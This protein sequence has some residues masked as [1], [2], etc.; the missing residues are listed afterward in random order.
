[1]KTILV[2][3]RPEKKL[4]NLNC[5]VLENLM[6]KQSLP[7]FKFTLETLFKFVAEFDICKA[8]FPLFYIV[9]C[10]LCSLFLKYQAG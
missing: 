4:S 3:E 5:G 7:I 9:F 1:L 8:L 2:L 6:N 10:L